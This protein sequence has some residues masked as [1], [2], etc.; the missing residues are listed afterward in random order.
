MDPRPLTRDEVTKVL[1]AIGGGFSGVRNRALLTVMYR[2]GLR[3]N[4]A[5]TL[6]YRDLVQRDEGWILRV[7]HPKG[8]ARG[9]LHR[10]LGID[11]RTRGV[12][13]PWLSIRR[14][15]HPLLFHTRHGEPVQTSYLRRLLP[16]LARRA[17]VT[18][19][20]HPHGLRHTFARELYEEQIGLVEIMGALGHTRLATTQ[21][22]LT[23]IGAT[24]VIAATAGREW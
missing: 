18:N 15:E 24:P 21:R 5:T 9:A 8:E 19:R 12:L 11:R 17:G 1:E 16:L 6:E 2:S 20:V 13:Q 4:E 23:S 7:S 3:S 22:Y 14:P 10:V